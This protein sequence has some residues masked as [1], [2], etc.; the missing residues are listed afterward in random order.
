MSYPSFSI[1]KLTYDFD[2]AGSFTMCN[3][4]SI[5]FNEE[6][7]KPF[8]KEDFILE[9]DS[10]WCKIESSFHGAGAVESR[11]DTQ[12]DHDN[13]CTTIIDGSNGA[14][15]GYFGFKISC[16]Y[17]SGEERIANLTIQHKDGW[18]ST[19][20]VIQHASKMLSNIEDSDV[21]IP[22]TTAWAEIPNKVI[23][24]NLYPDDYFVSNY[25]KADKIFYFYNFSP[26]N[27]P[28]IK[29]YIPKSKVI[30]ST[31]IK[32]CY[33]TN[34]KINTRI[35]LDKDDRFCNIIDARAFD[36]MLPAT[37]W[38]DSSEYTDF[39]ESVLV[40]RDF[41]LYDRDTSSSILDVYG[42]MYIVVCDY[43]EIGKQFVVPF[44]FI[45]STN[46]SKQKFNKIVA[47]YGSSNY[48]GTMQ[49]LDW[50]KFPNTDEGHENLS[51]VIPGTTAWIEAPDRYYK[52][53]VIDRYYNTDL[54]IPNY[55]RADKVIYLPNILPFGN[56]DLDLYI[57]KTYLNDNT[58]IVL[59]YDT[60]IES[61]T[62]KDLTDLVS[63]NW[64]YDSKPID[65]EDSDKYTDFKH[66]TVRISNFNTLTS[67]MPW[68]NQLDPAY[69]KVIFSICSC[70][71]ETGQFDLP[72]TIVVLRSG[73]P[74]RADLDAAVAKYGPSNYDGT[75]QNLDM[76]HFDNLDKNPY[77][78]YCKNCHNFTY[79]KNSRLCEPCGYSPTYKPKSGLPYFDKYSK[80]KSYAEC[81]E[82]AHGP[83][84][85][86]F[87][88]SLGITNYDSVKVTYDVV[89]IYPKNS[90][91][92][93]VTVYLYSSITVPQNDYPYWVISYCK[94]KEEN[95]SGDMKNDY[96]AAKVV[97]TI[98]ADVNGE[99]VTYKDK[100]LEY[101]FIQEGYTGGPSYDELKTIY[102]SE[103]HTELYIK[104]DNMKPYP[105]PSTPE[106]P[107]LPE[108][109]GNLEFEKSEV[110]VPANAHT[111]VVI[112]NAKGLRK[113]DLSKLTITS[114]DSW[115]SNITKTYKTNLKGNAY[116]WITYNTN[117]NSGAERSGK[118]NAS[119]NSKSAVL[120][121]NQVAAEDTTT[122]T[123]NI[124]LEKP[125]FNGE[126][127]V[128]VK[129][130]AKTSTA[131]LNVWDMT[132]EECTNKI[133]VR[134]NASWIKN[135]N[136]K[137]IKKDN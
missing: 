125:I 52:W 29:L 63:T 76:F 14:I 126:N 12:I 109:N 98:T 96:R 4:V 66:K 88:D 23:N 67:R 18:I 102:G 51:S 13:S 80:C 48:D 59:N 135:L 106:T 123:S 107:N 118:L 47:R 39:K 122:D 37:N 85:I 61:P 103:Y 44:T 120:T 72:F 25:G 137:Y 3:S 90:N 1:S 5:S 94:I 110:N 50:F 45:K 84:K 43:G 36:E 17:N 38:K 31:N 10:D 40:L 68:T 57:P 64:L 49:N 105:D 75:M 71:T 117:N 53:P 56:L 91:T 30:E 89:P 81:N 73:S 136:V 133:T 74:S 113:T 34:E 86:I 46:E 8:Y 116:L 55:G 92:D 35:Y 2:F 95:T 32:I 121:I 27:Y 82:I 111:N 104:P 26:Y 134:S 21:I 6:T 65:W 100:T 83:G 58:N 60:N 11:G 108:F 42:K 41:R 119:I 24:N 101:T 128:S 28:N 19:L 131:T 97:F 124:L 69:F 112:L 9:S 33:E 127:N 62:E 115:I 129:A 16:D 87:P 70:N 93:W 15:R 7:N 132:E 114:S 54:N 77:L 22:G 20:E 78:A 99:T 130:D 79:D